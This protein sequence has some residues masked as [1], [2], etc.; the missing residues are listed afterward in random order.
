MVAGET[1]SDRF[2][3]AQRPPAQCP[4]PRWLRHE[5]RRR[6]HAWPG[7]RITAGR[8][9]T[10]CSRS[11]PIR[12][13]RSPS[14]ARATHPTIPP[15]S[16]RRALAAASMPRS[17]A[18][19]PPGRSSS[20][21]CSVALR[22][23]CR[24]GRG[25]RARRASS[26]SAAA[27]RRRTSPRPTPRARS[28]PRLDAFAVTY[29]S[30]G[31]RGD[32]LA[33]RRQRPGS[34][35]RHRR[36]CHRAL[37]GR[38]DLVGQLPR[39]SSRAGRRRRQ[40]RRLRRHAARRVDRLRDVPRH[41]RQRR[42]DRSGRGRRRPCGGDGHGA[43][44]GLGQPRPTDAF[45]FRLSSGD[46]TSDTDNDQLPDAWETQ[47]NLDPRLSDANGDPDGDGAHEPGGVSSRAR[48]RSAGTRGTSR[49]AR[50]SGRS[51]PRLALFNPNAAPAAVLVRFLC[52]RACGVPD[53]PGQ[54]T[55]V[56]RLVTLAPFARGTLDVS[57]VAGL[58]DEEFAT[59]LES[60]QPIVADRTMTW[61]GTAYGSH[62][63][64]AMASPASAWYLAEGATI[65]GFRLFYLLQ[66][67]NAVEATVTIEYLLGR[68]LA[69]VTRTYTLAPRSRTTLDVST[70]HPSLRAAEVSARIVTAAETPILV[71][72]SMYLNA[73]GRLFGA[74]HASAGITTP[75]PTWSFAEG[76]TGPY[77]DTFLLVAN[78][79]NDAT[80]MRATFLLPSGATVERTYDGRRQEPLQHLG[81]PGGAG[82]RQNTGCLGRA[83][84]GG[85]PAV[86]R[87]AR[88]VV[89]G[90][91]GRQLAG[92][93]QLAGIA[94]HQRRLGSGRGHARRRQR[95]RHLRAHRQHLAVRRRRR[96]VT[97]SFEDDGARTA[98][99]YAVP[100]RSRINVPVRD[101]FPQA[102]GRRFAT[103][104]ESQGA[105][106]AQLVVERA[107]YADSGRER[108][109]SG[110]NALGTPL[111]AGARHHDHA[112]GVTPRVLV[113]SP[114]SSITM[115]EPRHRRAPDLLR[116]RISS[117]RPARR[118]TRS[119]TSRPASR[120][121]RAIS[122]RR[123]PAPSW[124]TSGGGQQLNRDFQGHIIVQVRP[125]SPGAGTGAGTR[126]RQCL[127]VDAA[128]TAASGTGSP[129]PR[130][131]RCGK[132]ALRGSFARA[133]AASC[134]AASAS[135]H[136][137]RG[138]R[139][140]RGAW[141]P[142]RSRPRPAAR[143]RSGR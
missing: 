45:L 132:P 136:R 23:R 20:R 120:A 142:R 100:A 79:S 134:I 111:G 42:C 96:C 72:R 131:R 135:R 130:C 14:P 123:A 119:A 66:N 15:C 9:A 22:A 73:G 25:R 21:P 36:R 112:A 2:P 88:D 49:K 58:A 35:P 133:C 127:S 13:A 128:V 3:C 44:H 47:F 105:V 70:Q 59:I 46:E 48:T 43:G 139:H 137:H 109:A 140:A 67:P 7:R 115:Q 77:F 69:P 32:G 121:S 61:D 124:T 82:T 83:R 33:D 18:S 27:R 76:A 40:R 138:I 122:A 78:P 6:S 126:R 110:T 1:R 86:R 62:A 97:L 102:M 28:A 89:A 74:G 141:L 29:A 53:I 95:D 75:A 55:I 92:G 5:N 129:M 84:V 71:E 4:G 26:M 118:S 114:A 50:R 41:Q 90:S 87:R 16:R 101:D 60:D 107:M 80:T 98:R 19:R 30:A 65:N 51:I 143:R 91:G 11:P 117:D 85:R 94:G 63:E 39:G 125:I 37:P 12:R 103:L 34:R 116:A 64:T 52:Q 17:R 10:A 24:A 108:W 113:V 99:E 31:T 56:R 57:T 81:R 68:G 106:P 38:P 54:D 93:A 8:P 104:V